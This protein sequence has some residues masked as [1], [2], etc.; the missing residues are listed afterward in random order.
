MLDFTSALYLGLRHGTSSLRPWTALTT[1]V[2]AALREPPESAQ[3][4]M[5]LAALIGVERATMAR[6]T[7]HAFWDLFTAF[8][9]EP[10][11]IFVDAGAYPIARWGTERTALSGV[12]VRAFGHHDPDALRA[13]LRR[14]KVRERPWIVTD[15]YCTGC[16]RLA[17]L[18]EYGSIAREAGGRLIIDD[19]QALGILGE[20]MS[21]KPPYGSG[22]GGSLRATGTSGPHVLLAASLAKGFGA[23]LCVIGGAMAAI[24]RFEAAS[25]TRVH[26]SPPSLADLHAAER[27]L[28][29]NRESGDRLRRRLAALVARFRHALNRLGL[30]PGRSLFPVQRL[31]GITGQAAAALY[32]R[33]EQLGVRAVL[34]RPACASNQ[35]LAFVITAAH[36]SVQIDRLVRQ[37]RVAYSR[38]A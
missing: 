21:A 10:R 19:T 11:A 12:A 14:A 26:A 30:T 13:R 9:N 37:V 29:I 32:R 8:D 7:L 35:E 38:A 18:A 17:P 23:P 36:R 25:E 31:A 6:S 2:P 20:H 5:A 16:G 3:I 34:R 1:G 22:G 24:D 4:A 28:R 27:A 15:G 33:L